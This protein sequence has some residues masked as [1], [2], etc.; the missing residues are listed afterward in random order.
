MTTHC[1]LPPS[2]PAAES[3]PQPCHAPAVARI[4]VLSSRLLP[5]LRIVAAPVPAELP[6]RR[7]RGS[8]GRRGGRGPD[9][10]RAWRPESCR[11]TGKCPIRTPPTTGSTGRPSSSPFRAGEQDLRQRLSHRLLPDPAGSR[12]GSQV[13]GA[14]A[15]ALPRQ[16]PA[17]ARRRPVQRY[18]GAAHRRIRR[19]HGF[20]RLTADSGRRPGELDRQPRRRGLD[21]A[22]DGGGD[23]LLTS[24][25]REKGRSTSL[26]VGIY[27]AGG[28][29]VNAGIY[30]VG[31]GGAALH[32]GERRHV[33][34]VRGRTQRRGRRLHGFGRRGRAE[35]HDHRPF[36]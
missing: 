31:R 9:P 2:T 6:A 18:R 24:A 7:R 28:V 23:E 30:V 17:R 20:R 11:S 34:R 13:Q 15:G 4:M 14:G 12:P 33:L 5:V 1:P 36:R 3:T 21:W 26:L 35:G 32:A 22:G 29:A 16:P 25:W 27:D 10:D 8:A 19:G